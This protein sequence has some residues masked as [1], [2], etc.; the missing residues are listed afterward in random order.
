MCSDSVARPIMQDSHS[1]DWGS[2]PHRS[3]YKFYILKVIVNGFFKKTLQYSNVDM[4]WKMTPLQKHPIHP[5]SD[6]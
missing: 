1:C 5:L 4:T 3:T 2:N 6:L